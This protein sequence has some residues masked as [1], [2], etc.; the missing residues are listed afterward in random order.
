MTEIEQKLAALQ[1]GDSFFPSGSVSFSWGLE[2]L[3]ETGCIST[4][5]GV[6]AF[7]IGQ[8][9]AKWCE[10][11]RVIVVAAHRAGTN[12]D[13]IAKIDNFVETATP[14]SA[15]RSGSKR[16]GDALLGAFARIG[17][18]QAATYRQR[19]KRGEAYAHA[20]VMQG[21]LW[22]YAGLSESDAVALS[23]HTFCTGLL[24][25]GIRLGCLTHTEAQFALGIARKEAAQ[26]ATRPVPPIKSISTCSIEAEIAVMRHSKYQTRMFAN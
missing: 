20:P 9:R 21:Y 24:G 1:Y 18:D 14:S 17:F 10:C 11:D 25:A 16:M 26:M 12:A 8:L 15:V 19:V 5:E 23:A 6:Q 3:V 22:K 7:V 4:G 2:G 13:E